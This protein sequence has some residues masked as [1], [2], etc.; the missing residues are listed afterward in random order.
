[1]TFNSAAASLGTVFGLDIDPV[2]QVKIVAT[3]SAVSS[4]VI[5][6]WRTWF[7]SKTLLK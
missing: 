3:I 1:M 5:V 7:T 6:I 2:M 4:A